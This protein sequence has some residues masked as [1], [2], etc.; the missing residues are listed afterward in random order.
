MKLNSVLL[1]CFLVGSILLMMG[2]NGGSFTASPL[3]NKF[4]VVLSAVFTVSFIIEFLAGKGSQN[5]ENAPNRKRNRIITSTIFLPLI[6]FTFLIL[7]RLGAI[8]LISYV[9]KA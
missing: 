1:G 8:N 7:S 4:A 5:T 2:L 9:L 6:F 3:G